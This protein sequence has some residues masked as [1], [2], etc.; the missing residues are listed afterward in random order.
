MDNGKMEKVTQVKEE[1]GNRVEKTKNQIV[2]RN[3]FWAICR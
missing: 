3:A 2:G 1:G